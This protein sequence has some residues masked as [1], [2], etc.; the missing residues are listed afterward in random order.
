MSVRAKFIQYALV[1][2]LCLL[3]AIALAVPQI[4]SYQGKLNDNNGVP[5]DG[6]VDITFTIYDAASGGNAL[7]TETWEGDN[8]VTVRRGIFSIELGS[9]T[10][11]VTTIF[12]KDNLYLGIKV[13]DDSEMIPRQRF[14]SGAYAFRAEPSNKIFLNQYPLPSL[15]GV[16]RYRY[17]PLVTVT[18]PQNEVWE[19]YQLWITRNGSR[20]F[21]SN[22]KLVVDNTDEYTATI[23]YLEGFDSYISVLLTH[24]AP[25]R[26]V[27]GQILQ[28]Q[29]YVE[30]LNEAMWGTLGVYYYKTTF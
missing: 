1:L 19:I 9:I 14:T 20:K 2:L 29:G 23:D 24:I 17:H 11:L 26:V 6:S 8:S 25:T 16:M 5:V 12:G 21:I 27:G 3:P 22:I 15:D 7:W 18:V 4:M 28:V 13:G 30:G 10:P